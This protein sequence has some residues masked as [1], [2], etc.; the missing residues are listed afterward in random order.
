MSLEW[1]RARALQ[2]AAR[3]R[4]LARSEERDGWNE[5]TLQAPAPITVWVEPAPPVRLVPASALS[6]ANQERLDA[7]NPGELLHQY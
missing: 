6:A 4:Q 5:V 7:A 1:A 2:N 3:L